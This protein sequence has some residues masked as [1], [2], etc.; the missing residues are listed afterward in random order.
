[1]LVFKNFK[2][3][4]FCTQKQLKTISF[5]NTYLFPIP[6]WLHNTSHLSTFLSLL[7]LFLKQTTSY[8]SLPL[9]SLTLHLYLRPL[10]STCITN[11][12]RKH[13]QRDVYIKISTRLKVIP[14]Q[15]L[16]FVRVESL[17]L[18]AWL[19]I[20]ANIKSRVYFQRLFSSN[21]YL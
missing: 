6:I 14:L 10:S 20:E 16:H 9:L 19:K 17:H 5:T 7:F 12:Q 3:L 2:C 15:Y 1:M 21:R 18:S 13:M 11:S 8:R 4:H